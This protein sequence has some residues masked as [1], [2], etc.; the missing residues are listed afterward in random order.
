MLPW[1]LPQHVRIQRGG[2]QGVRTPP[3]LENYKNKG[4]I[5]NTGPDPLK[6]TKLP[7]QHSM[8]GHHRPASEGVSLAGRWWPANSGI[9][10][11]PLFIKLKKKNRCQSWTTSEKTFWI[12]TFQSNIMFWRRWCLKNFKMAWTMLATLDIR[13]GQIQRAGDR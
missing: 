7:S 4:F 8:L 13:H 1:W 6:I 10:I 3:P 9:W 5:S 11:L 2:G 12:R